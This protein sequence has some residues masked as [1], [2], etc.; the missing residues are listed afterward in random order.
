MEGKEP[1]IVK[2]KPSES[3]QAA[4]VYVPLIKTVVA[5]DQLYNGVHPW[6][7]DGTK[8]HRKNWQDNLN[9]LKALN[10]ETYV[11]GHKTAG[12]ADGPESIDFVRGYLQDFDK[13]LAESKNADE[14]K[15]KLSA[16]A[17]FP[18]GAAKK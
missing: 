2:M 13:F 8:T 3:E 14:L 6:L 10:A 5:G 12:K 16:K 4:A 9:A 17:A 15:T 11:P 18:Q 7:V 1:K